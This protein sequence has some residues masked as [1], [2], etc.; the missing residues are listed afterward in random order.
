M[1]WSPRPD[2]GTAW[3]RIFGDNATSIRAGFGLRNFTQP[4]QFYWDA[5][6]AQALLYYQ[7]FALT[8]NTS[9]APGTFVP[10]SLSYGQT[11]PP[12]AFNPVTFPQTAPLTNFSFINGGVPVEGINSNIRMPYTE[13]WNLGIQRALA[14]NTVL[15][16]RYNGNRTIH[17]WTTFNYN[18]V[19]I[20]ENGFLAEFKN[21]QLNYLANGKKNFSDV[22]GI[23][24]P[25]LDAAFANTPSAFTNATFLGY[26]EQ[27]TGGFVCAAACREWA[28]D[29]GVLLCAGR[30]QL[31]TLRRERE[32]HGCQAPA[33]PSTS[34]R[35]IPTLRVRRRRI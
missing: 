21:A 9:G 6:S 18:E 32:V 10:G 17:N 19:N 33:I 11:L 30:L 12:Y 4:Y 14:R 35:Q 22:N 3:A 5:A 27:R 7:T 2:K 28:I 23:H 13:S 15:E 26:L 29:A 31:Y 16:V 34:S 25:I 1:N 8:G 20:V 24:T